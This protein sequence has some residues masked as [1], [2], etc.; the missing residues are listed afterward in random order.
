LTWEDFREMYI[1]RDGAPQRWLPSCQSWTRLSWASKTSS[2]SSHFP[3]FSECSFSMMR[4]WGIRLVLGNSFLDISTP[5]S[6]P[7][8]FSAKKRES[9]SIQNK[10]RLQL[11][12]DLLE[13]LGTRMK[14]VSEDTKTRKPLEHHKCER[15]C[16]RT[17]LAQLIEIRRFTA[18]VRTTANWLS[19]GMHMSMYFWFSE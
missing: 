4:M 13:T 19:K 18:K 7:F 10:A 16:Y 17:R 14:S 6:F 1:S 3:L 2:P 15:R 11:Y 12:L 8:N 5:R 9:L